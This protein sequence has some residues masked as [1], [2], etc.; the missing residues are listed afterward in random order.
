MQILLNDPN[1]AGGSTAL[2]LAAD[3][4]VVGTYNAAILKRCFD[5]INAN[6]RE[7]YG[8]VGPFVPSANV[9]AFSSTLPLDNHYVMPRQS[10]TSELTFAAGASPVAGGMVTV[11]LVADG[12]PAHAPNFGPFSQYQNASYASNWN[13]T[14]GAVN[15]VNLFCSELYNQNGD[16]GTLIYQYT[17]FQGSENQ[18]LGTPVQAPA[19]TSINVTHGTNPTLTIG[20]GGSGLNPNYVP[21][22]GAFSVSG[23]DGAQVGPGPAG[24]AGATVVVTAGSVQIPLC[25]SVAAGDVL[26]IN[27]TPPADGALQDSSGVRMGAITGATVTAA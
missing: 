16:T 18:P 22:I 10:I 3:G 26:T 7:L 6:F 15:R 13:N 24:L 27:Y 1:A 23:S 12:N 20:I 8:V 9:A 25:G 14:A 5:A 19:V 11:E 2:D 21:A 17:I 4:W